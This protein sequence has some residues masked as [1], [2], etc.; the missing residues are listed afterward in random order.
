MGDV[1]LVIRA[2]VSIRQLNNAEVDAKTNISSIAKM[3][4]T[5]LLYPSFEIPSVCS[6]VDII[7]NSA[8]ASCHHLANYFVQLYNR[9]IQCLISEGCTSCTAFQSAFYRHSFH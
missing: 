2:A 7:Y 3:S 5:T 9:N 6:R 4:G 1:R 8:D